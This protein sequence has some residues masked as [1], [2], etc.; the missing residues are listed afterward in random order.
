MDKKIAAYVSGTVRDLSEYRKQAADACLQLGIVPVAVEQVPTAGQDPLAVSLRALDNADIYV[1]IIGWRYGF[2][3]EGQN[4]SITELE[5]RHA[6]ERGVPCLIFIMD[7]KH[8]IT[9]TEIDAATQPQMQQFRKQMLEQNIVASFTTPQD[10]RAKLIASLTELKTRITSHP[11]ACEGYAITLELDLPQGLSDEEIHAHI[12]DIA[13]DLDSLHRAH[14]GH[15]LLVRDLEI[16]EE[17]LV[18]EGAPS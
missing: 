11:E 6:R 7:D 13:D 1:G 2:I 9:P 14:G 8:P 5:Y 10:F 4:A 12:A 15:G 17:S 16:Y 18:A 3:P